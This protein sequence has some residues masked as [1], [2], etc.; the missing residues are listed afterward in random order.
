VQSRRLHSDKNLTCLHWRRCGTA[1]RPFEDSL[2][3][4]RPSTKDEAGDDVQRLHGWREV[5]SPPLPS[6]CTAEV[7][8]ACSSPCHI[9]PKLQSLRSTPGLVRWRGRAVQ[10]AWSLAVIIA[11]I[12]CPA[13]GGHRSLTP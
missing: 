9:W 1:P 12:L 2:T 4:V 3:L 11:H 5:R 6:H 10:C 7:M 8:P 13:A